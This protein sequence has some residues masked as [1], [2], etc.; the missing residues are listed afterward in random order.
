M[1][2]V[3]GPAG[4]RRPHQPD[5]RR[6]LVRRNSRP[7]E[8]VPLLPHLRHLARSKYCN[9]RPPDCSIHR[10]II[11]L[12]RESRD[13]ADDVPRIKKAVEYLIY[14]SGR[15]FELTCQIGVDWNL[16]WNVPPS[17]EVEQ[18]IHKTKLI[19]CF[20]RHPETDQQVQSDVHYRRR[21]RS[22]IDA[23][24]VRAALQRHGQLHLSPRRCPPPV[25]QS[26][27]LRF[28]YQN[29][30]IDFESVVL[31]FVCR[32]GKVAFADRVVV[33]VQRFATGVVALPANS[34]G[35]GRLLTEAGTNR[36]RLGEHC[37]LFFGS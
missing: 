3:Q 5:Q 12:G 14:P 31:R 19:L 2:Q 30:L 37:T 34:S 35:R 15:A 1:G 23:P 27:R 7:M 4:P 21:W 32:C 6:L 36:A 11:V 8:D 16:T 22:Q 28:R 25:G 20:L 26:I 33:R 10:F 18:K 24:R 9:Q 13:G 29:R 17:L